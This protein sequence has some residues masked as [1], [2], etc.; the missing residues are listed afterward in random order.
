MNRVSQFL[1]VRYCWGSPV[2]QCGDRIPP[3]FRPEFGRM[4]KGLPQAPFTVPAGS[5]F[6]R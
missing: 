2:R 3:N 4:L 5:S 1:I 6:E